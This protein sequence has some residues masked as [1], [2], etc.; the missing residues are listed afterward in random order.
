MLMTS[1]ARKDPLWCPPQMKFSAPL[2]AEARE[3]EEKFFS[4]MTSRAAADREKNLKALLALSPA[5]SPEREVVQ[6]PEGASVPVMPLALS[7]TSTAHFDDVAV[8]P[9]GDELVLVQEDLGQ[10]LRS[11]DDKVI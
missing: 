10:Q 3:I 2:S 11:S 8:S 6:T 4:L 5:P 7:P 9:S 1:T